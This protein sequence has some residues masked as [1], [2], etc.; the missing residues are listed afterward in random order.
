MNQFFKC[1]KCFSRN[2]FNLEKCLRNFLKKMEVY[3]VIGSIFI[4]YQLFLAEKKEWVN[5]R[6]T[7]AWQLVTTK[8]SGNT[9]KIEALEY[10][11]SKGLSLSGINLSLVPEQCD[12]DKIKFFR[13]ADDAKDKIILNPRVYLK[14]VNLEKANLNYSFLTDTNF[15]NANLSQAKLNFSDFQVSKLH[16]ANLSNTK[17]HNADFRGSELQGSDLSGAILIGTDFRY[18][19]LD[20]AD[21]NGAILINAKLESVDL[22]RVKNLTC[23]QIV[24]AKNWELSIRSQDLACGKPIPEKIQ[25]K[26]TENRFIFCPSNK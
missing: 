11:N 7:S 22:R 19:N 25:K 15:S 20:N 6:I 5:T 4:A 14:N 3:I 21:F 26:I 8:A 12:P 10:L 1:F 23:Q 9:G 18:S 16:G 17:L 24:E 2:I 13:P